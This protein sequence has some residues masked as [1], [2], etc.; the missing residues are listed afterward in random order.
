MFLVSEERFLV[1]LQKA[2]CLFKKKSSY[3]ILLIFSATLKNCPLSIRGPVWQCSCCSLLPAT[4]CPLYDR[5]TEKKNLA[6]LHSAE[7]VPQN[8]LNFPVIVIVAWPT[9][10][11]KGFKAF[12]HQTFLCNAAISWNAWVLQGGVTRDSS[13]DYIETWTFTVVC[14]WIV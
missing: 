10:W 6:D 8:H 11:V 13:I 1:V 12:S 3:C 2:P 7:T 5:E 9:C 14:F 4:F